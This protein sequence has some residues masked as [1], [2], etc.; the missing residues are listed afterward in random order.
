[1]QRTFNSAARC[2]EWNCYFLSLSLFLAHVHSHTRSLLFLSLSLSLSLTHTHTHTFSLS[3][4]L[5]L[6]SA[7]PHL[8]ANFNRYFRTSFGWSVLRYWRCC[9]RKFLPN[10]TRKRLL[11]T[12]MVS[13]QVLAAAFDELV[14]AWC[15]GKMKVLCCMSSSV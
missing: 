10:G 2:G 5:P 4:T 14:A 9:W 3:L 11:S 7:E 8:G 12:I 13:P 1:M 6:S 15:W